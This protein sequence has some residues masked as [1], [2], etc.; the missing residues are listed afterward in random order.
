MKR[1]VT[2]WLHWIRIPTQPDPEASSTNSF[3]II[4][5]T[6][7][8]ISLA[9][10]KHYW[11]PISLFSLTWGDCVSSVDR[12]DAWWFAADNRGGNDRLSSEKISYRSKR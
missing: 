11:H 5:N 4:F 6:S 7:K 2:A 1:P 10:N 3:I 8:G 9:A 12:P